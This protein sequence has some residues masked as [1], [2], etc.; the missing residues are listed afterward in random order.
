MPCVGPTGSQKAVSV[1]FR[2]SVHPHP[3]GS[4][5][6]GA[7]RSVKLGGFAPLF[8][9][10]TAN[11]LVGVDSTPAQVDFSVSS[12]CFMKSGYVNCMRASERLNSSKSE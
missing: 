10:L 7:A 11:Y 3:S 5:L 4:E 9:H 12:L 1:A 8:S 6:V 2:C